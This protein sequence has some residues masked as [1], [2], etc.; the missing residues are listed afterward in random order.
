VP[1]HQVFHVTPYSQMSPVSSVTNI[2][3][4]TN[5]FNLDHRDSVL[6]RGHASTDNHHTRHA[7]MVNINAVWHYIGCTGVVT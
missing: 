3:R 6:I 2:F 7:M 1:T 5:Q 4:A